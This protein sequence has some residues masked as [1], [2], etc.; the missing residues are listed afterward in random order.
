[1]G[2]GFGGLERFGEDERYRLTFM[3]DLITLEGK[4]TVCEWR[5]RYRVSGSRH[6]VVREH[7]NDTSFRQRKPLRAALAFVK[8][9]VPFAPLAFGLFSL[10]SRAAC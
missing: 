10:M 5:S 1:L 9:I 2:A 4:K 8:M 7:A 6:V 3:A